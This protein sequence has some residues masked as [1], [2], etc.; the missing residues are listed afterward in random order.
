MKDISHLLKEDDSLSE[1]K[2]Y[3]S[4]F[5]DS[6][7]LINKSDNYYEIFYDERKLLE[8][9][10]S[11]LQ[12]LNS[13]KRPRIKNLQYYQDCG[14]LADD[15]AEI[16]IDPLHKNILSASN[17]IGWIDGK[18]KFGIGELNVEVSYA[19]PLFCLLTEPIYLDSDFHIQFENL[20]TIKL[21]STKF[22]AINEDLTK[23]LYYL[24]SFYLKK[25]RIVFKVNPLIIDYDMDLTEDYLFDFSDEIKRERVLRRDNFKSVEPLTLYNFAQLNVYEAKSLY[26]YRILEFFMESAQKS[27]IEKIRY[28]DKISSAEIISI[29]NNKEKSLLKILFDDVSE[30]NP[31][32]KKQIISYA[33]AGKIIGSKNDYSSIPL[34]LYKYRNS[35]VHAKEKEIDRTTLPDIFS[36]ERKDSPWIKIL[37]VLSIECIKKYN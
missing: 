7:Y 1:L 4:L 21:T 15:Y 18:L 32:L 2:R 19:S 34:K 26:L 6:D 8:I 14:I 35:I 16:C 29:S 20:V 24:N 9:S 30:K 3:F 31:K 22:S 27:R 23:A 25:Y 13:M 17:Y 37:E 28:N 5:I 11:S 36:I 12:S 33:K 10:I